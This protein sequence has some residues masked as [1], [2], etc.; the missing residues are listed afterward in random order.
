[1]IP[2][3]TPQDRQPQIGLSAWDSELRPPGCLSHA[4]ALLTVI[5]EETISAVSINI[6][7]NT[8]VIIA[9][10]FILQHHVHNNKISMVDHMIF[11]LIH[12]SKEHTYTLRLIIK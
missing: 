2:M 12:V 7:K 5:M 6:T 3:L 1:M 11:T 4:L 8:S 9:E 10:L